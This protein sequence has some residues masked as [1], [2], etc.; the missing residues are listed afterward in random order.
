LN[1][2][3][4]NHDIRNTA[5]GKVLLKAGML[6]EGTLRQSVLRK[7]EVTDYVHYAIL[8]EDWDIR[9][10]IEYYNRLPCYFENFI[11]V[12]NLSNREIYLVCIEKQPGN[13]EK[14]WVPG[15][16][17]AICKGGQKVGRINL[18]IG[19]VDSLYY[20]GQIGY[21]IDEEYRGNGYA[22]QAC[23]LLLPVAKAHKMEKLLITN[24]VDNTSSKRVCEKLG[25]RLVR[26]APLPEWHDLYARGQRFSNIYEWNVE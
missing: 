23:R 26:V 6:H 19:Y 18:R 9:K 22:G 16:E 20:G 15:Y 11:E 12:P 13:T 1:R 5:S 8:K 21:D 7:G 2:L 4:A 25:A 14:K 24:N 10:E 3:W 17:F